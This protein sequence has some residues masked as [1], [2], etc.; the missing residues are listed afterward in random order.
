ML[1]GNSTCTAW[2]AIR[3]PASDRTW[4]DP[5]SRGEHTT[6]TGGPPYTRGP[7]VSLGDLDVAMVTSSPRFSVASGVTKSV[8]SSGYASTPG[9]G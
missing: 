1:L 5:C 6:H 2:G 8:S 9:Q 3:S 4:R 7:S